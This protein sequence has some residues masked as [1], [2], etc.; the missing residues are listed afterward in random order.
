VTFEARKGEVF[1][2]EVFSERLGLPTDPFALIQRVSKNDKGEE[3]VS[4]V[5]ELYGFDSD[6]G[7]EC[8]INRHP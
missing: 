3:Q 6:I 1:W 7:A 4:D 2:A 8:N 5:K